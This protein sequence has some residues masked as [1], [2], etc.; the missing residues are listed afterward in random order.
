MS[1]N[2]FLLNYFT[3]DEGEGSKEMASNEADSILLEQKHNLSY[4]AILH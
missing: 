1:R 3:L 4:L 2:F